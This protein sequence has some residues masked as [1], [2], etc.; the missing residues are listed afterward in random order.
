MLN[1]RLVMFAFV[2]PCPPGQEV[3]HLDGDKLNPSLDNLV[4]GTR[5]E[6]MRDMVRHGAHACFRL[7]PTCKYGHPF[8]EANTTYATRK[9]DGKRRRECR[10]CH[11]NRERARRARRKESA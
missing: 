8:D 4:Y 2:G 6:N 3:R 5:S 1:H 10:I 7:K 9:R 11:A